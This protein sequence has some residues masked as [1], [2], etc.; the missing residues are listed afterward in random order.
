[1]SIESVAFAEWEDRLNKAISSHGLPIAARDIIEVLA[2]SAE[3]SAPLTAHDHE[4]L[5]THAGL[6]AADLTPEA[7]SAV[8]LEIG[9][10]RARAAQDVR[11]RSYDTQ[12]VAAMLKMA[13]AN[14][15][16][17][18]ANGTLYSVKTSPGSIHLFPNWQFPHNRML[19]G[20]RD[21]ILALPNN[22]HPIEVEAFMTERSEALRGMS[23]VEWLASDGAVAAVSS[24]ADE[25]AWE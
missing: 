9:S 13:P 2:D 21:V 1:M 15:R 3:P 6:A 8:E 5:T 22:Y 12:Q 4:F 20:L 18:V 16:R 19:P 24:L 7:L 17:C 14:V 11:G 23:P 25:R 10:N